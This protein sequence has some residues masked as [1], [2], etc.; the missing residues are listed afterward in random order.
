MSRM[1]HA[2]IDMPMETINNSKG[3]Q[4]AHVT[5]SVAEPRKLECATF[6]V[7]EAALVIG[8]SEATVRRWCTRGV[9]KRVPKLRHKKISKAKVFKFIEGGDNV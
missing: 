1:Y 9:F 2:A 5:K 4:Q 8:V 3:L 7:K 6:S